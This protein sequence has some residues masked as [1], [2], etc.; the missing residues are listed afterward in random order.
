ML[1]L[2]SAQ[3][4]LKSQEIRIDELGMH[5][6]VFDGVAANSLMTVKGTIMELHVTYIRKRA[7]P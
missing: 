6:D 1:C 3:E 2:Y 4:T 5:I 7:S